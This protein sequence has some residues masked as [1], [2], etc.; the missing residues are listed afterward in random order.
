MLTFDLRRRSGG[1]NSAVRTLSSFQ[2]W[3]S[4]VE[5]E[6]ED[7]YLHPIQRRHAAEF[8]LEDL[9]SELHEVVG[10]MDREDD[11]DLRESSQEDL[12]TFDWSHDPQVFVGVREDFKT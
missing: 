5:E 9:S 2:S 11:R 4:D 7:V 1:R 8:D 6:E 3:Q 12:L 10:S